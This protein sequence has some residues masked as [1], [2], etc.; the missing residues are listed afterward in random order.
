VVGATI[1]DHVTAS[2]TVYVNVIDVNDNSP[3]FRDVTGDVS[4]SEDADVGYSVVTVSATDRD[5]GLC[6]SQSVE[7]LIQLVLLI[8]NVQSASAESG[9]ADT[10][11]T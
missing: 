3:E 10:S 5:S 2:V 1:S 4:V 9:G 11:E 6:L 7:C 8:C